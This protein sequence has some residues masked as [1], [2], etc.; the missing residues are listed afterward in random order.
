MNGCHRAWQPSW[1]RLRRSSRRQP[2][3]GAEAVGSQDRNRYRVGGSGDDGG[4]GIEQRA[5]E[6]KGRESEEPTEA[7]SGSVAADARMRMA[8]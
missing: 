3:T 1:W 7:E 5:D 8:K 2:W 4:R 6:G